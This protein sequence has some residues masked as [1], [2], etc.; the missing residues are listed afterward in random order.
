MLC[1]CFE[2]FILVGF[3]TMG[4]HLSCLFSLVMLLCTVVVCS[5]FFGHIKSYFLKNK[6]ILSSF[7]V[8][9]N[10]PTHKHQNSKDSYAKVGAFLAIQCACMS[11]DSF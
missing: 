7:L 2:Q 9:K 3:E 8:H 10:D 4:Y 1:S 5:C 11:K 6:V